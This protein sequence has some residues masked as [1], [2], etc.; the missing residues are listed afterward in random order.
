MNVLVIMNKNYCKV[1]KVIREARNFSC[2]GSHEEN[3][4]FIKFGCVFIWSGLDLMTHGWECLFP[5]DRRWIFP[6]FSLFRGNFGKRTVVPIYI[7]IVIIE[8]LCE[9][10][11]LFYI[12]NGFEKP[13]QANQ[14]GVGFKSFFFLFI[15]YKNRTACKNQ[16]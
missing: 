11:C 16:F 10:C 15:H 12:A 6:E 13:T 2:W 14:E 1:L 9:K 3:R 8:H 7:K 4:I 5:E